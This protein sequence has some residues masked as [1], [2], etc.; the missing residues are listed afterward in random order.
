[1]MC[2]SVVLPR[3]GGPN[4]ST[5]SSASPRFGRADEDLELLARLALPDVFREALRAQRPLDRF[6]VGRGRAALTHAA[7]RQVNSSVWMLMRPHYRVRE[8]R[9]A[10]SLLHVATLLLLAHR[11]VGGGVRLAAEGRGADARQ[12]AAALPGQSVAR[13]AAST[14]CAA[15]AVAAHAEPRLRRPISTPP[16][17]GRM[18]RRHDHGS[19]ALAA[20][21]ATTA[22]ERAGG[23]GDARCRAEPAAPPAHA[24]RA[25]A[26]PVAACSAATPCAMGG[27]LKHGPPARA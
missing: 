10:Q 24:R 23:A 5:W 8:M 7:T 16:S 11:P 6:L 20:T 25:A 21:A 27:R 14:A 1:M 13:S 4:S 9:L 26:S 12:C 3:P 17:A 15:V 2:D 22:H 19:H 18:I